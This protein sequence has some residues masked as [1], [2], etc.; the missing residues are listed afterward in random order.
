VETLRHRALVQA[1]LEETM[2]VSQ[3]SLEQLRK[4]IATEEQKRTAIIELGALCYRMGIDQRNNPR[5][6][7]GERK[8]WD[9][10]YD[11]ARKSFDEMLR[12]NGGHM[13]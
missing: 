1:D 11:K 13:H 5:K 10:G 3:I 2:R 6:L 8:L 9:I 7:E 12:R 4:D